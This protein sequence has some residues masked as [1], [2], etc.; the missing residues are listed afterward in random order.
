MSDGD[1]IVWGTAND[2]DNIVWGT[3]TD[4][5]NIVW[6]TSADADVT[7]G[8]DAGDEGAVFSDEVVEPLPSLDLEFGDLVPLPKTSSLLTLGTVSIGG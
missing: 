6:G 8:S 5:D 4:G 3:A 7:W 2:G 1:N